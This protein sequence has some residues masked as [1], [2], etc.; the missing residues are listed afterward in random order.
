MTR[1]VSIAKLLLAL[2][3][4]TTVHGAEPLSHACKVKIYRYTSP[5]SVVL[6]SERS[7]N[8]SSSYSSLNIQRIAYIK[9][10][11]WKPVQIRLHSN[12]PNIFA[13]ANSSGYWFPKIPA[14]GRNPFIAGANEPYDTRVSLRGIKCDA[15][16]N[17]ISEALDPYVGNASQ[18]V[19]SLKSSER[20]L[21]SSVFGSSVSLNRIEISNQIGAGNRAYT[22][23]IPFGKQTLHVGPQF[24]NTTVPAPLLI[25]ELVHAWQ[26]QRGILVGVDSVVTGQ[27]YEYSLGSSGSPYKAWQLFNVEQQAQIVEDWYRQGHS[28]SNRRFPYIRDCVRPGRT[29]CTPAG[30]L[31]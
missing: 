7:G 11:G 20:S 18:R 2:Q 1:R 15:S 17:P 28:T 3:L 5:N 31:P 25:H 24:Y 8:S 9:N 6:D 10:T 22:T 23:S 27:T 13:G 12:N 19:R 30:T 21:A 4:P 14:G 26:Y 16:V 29:N